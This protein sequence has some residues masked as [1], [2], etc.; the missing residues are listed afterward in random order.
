MQIAVTSPT[1]IHVDVLNLF[2][3]GSHDDPMTSQVVLNI[4]M[5]SSPFE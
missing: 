1:L 2:V 3:I 5:K 4:L